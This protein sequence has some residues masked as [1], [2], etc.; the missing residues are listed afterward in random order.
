MIT[1]DNEKELK[2]LLEETVTGLGGTDMSYVNLLKYLSTIKELRIP[3]RFMAGQMVF[4]KYKPQDDRFLRSQKAYD[5]YPLVVITKVHENGF[6]GINLHY[7]SQKWRRLLFDAMEDT[8]PI[9]KSGDESLSR[10]GVS[11]NRLSTPRR[12]AFFK[13]CYKRYVIEGFRRRPIQIPS[14]FWDVLV[15]VDLSLFVKGRKMNVRRMS[16]NQSI[17]SGNKKP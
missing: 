6:E 13:P 16:Y 8:L 7:I 1:K 11:Y 14:E 15:D 12:F 3:P 17:I 10:L 2:K 4:F 9:K 5:V